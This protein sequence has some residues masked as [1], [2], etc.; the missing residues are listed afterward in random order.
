MANDYSIFRPQAVEQ[1]SSPD[2]LDK[3]LKVTNPRVWIALLAVLALLVGLTAWGI[4]GT[5]NTS[6]SVKAVRLDDGIMC[7]IDSNEVE[8]VK[9]GNNAYVNGRPGKVKSVAT[10]PLSQEEVRGALGSDFL[11]ETVLEDKWGYQV[12]FDVADE[13]DLPERVPLTCAITTERVSPFEYM[14][15]ST[16]T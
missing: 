1:M 8:Y 13:N 11:S 6:V 16:G 14:A 3:F 9:A 2:E 15:Q 7:F 5:V 12:T 10:I 4:F